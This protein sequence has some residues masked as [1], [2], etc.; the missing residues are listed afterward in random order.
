MGNTVEQGV[1]AVH[2]GSEAFA[3]ASVNP[4]S[5]ID[6][7]GADFSLE[8]AALVVNAGGTLCGIPLRCVVEI[9]RPLPIEPLATS[10]NAVVGLALVRGKATAVVDLR[11]LLRAAERLESSSSSFSS[12]AQRFVAL[13]VR[14]RLESGAHEEHVSVLRVDQVYGVHRFAAAQLASLPPLFSN[15][16]APVDAVSLQGAELV[17]MLGTTRLIPPEVWTLVA[18]KRG[19][20]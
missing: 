4:I 13:R 16:N 11:L 14:L 19:A 18:A 8:D 7:A 20:Q 2:N 12:S 6:T 1:N 10:V 3:A 5:G 9:M 17:L 15:T